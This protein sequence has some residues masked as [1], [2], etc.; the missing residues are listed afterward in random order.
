MKPEPPVDLWAKMD[1]AIA[2][3]G[4]KGGPPEGCF[5]LPEMMKRKGISR[6]TA[7]NI[8]N[9]LVAAGRIEAGGTCGIGNAKY[10]R[11]K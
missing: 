8:I 3:C 6:T 9:R 1:A 5:T 2:D 4:P 10:Y 11:V 7:R